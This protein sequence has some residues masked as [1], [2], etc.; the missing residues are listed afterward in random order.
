MYL[1]KSRELLWEALM[2][3]DKGH[4]EEAG[5]LALEVATLVKLRQGWDSE[6]CLADYRRVLEHGQRGD[7]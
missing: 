2:Q 7:C 4:W 6:R 1:E 3:L 5:R